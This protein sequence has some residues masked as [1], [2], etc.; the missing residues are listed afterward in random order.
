[1]ALSYNQTLSNLRDCINDIQDELNR[2]GLDGSKSMTNWASQ[3]E[4]I[5]VQI[6]K[7]NNDFEDIYNAIVRQGQDPDKND[8]T[9]YAD[10][11]LAI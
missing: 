9:S 11:I 8:R 4:S 5:R 7:D 3:L 2:L 10:A 1:M 6:E